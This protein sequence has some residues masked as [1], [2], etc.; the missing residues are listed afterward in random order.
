MNVTRTTA[1][2][3]TA[4]I[5]V[6]LLAGCRRDMQDQPH[7]KPL[8]PS[9]FFTDGR[10]ARP[11][12]AGTIARDELLLT[13]AAHTGTLNGAFL[14]Q[15]PKPVNKAMLMHGQERFNIYC[16]PCHG[17]LGDGN[18]MI[19]KRGFKWPA[20]LH[21]DRL[22]NAPPGYIYQVIANGFGAMPGYSEQI[23]ANDRW[24]IVAYIHALQL[25][26]HATPSDVPPAERGQLEVR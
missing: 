14:N 5:A 17:L 16:S 2:L 8:A 6:L 18:G 19:A 21:T 12:P 7:Y 9:R 10:S 4:G 22:R 23:P 20:D 11:I 24:D 3:L 25:S 1:S 15:V 26:R 13:D